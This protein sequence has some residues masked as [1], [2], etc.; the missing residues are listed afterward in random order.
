MLLALILL[1]VVMLEPGMLVVHMTEL[2]VFKLEC[3]E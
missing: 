1:L 3:W 2:L